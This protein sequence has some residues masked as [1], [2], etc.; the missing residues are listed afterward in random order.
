MIEVGIPM[1][2][3][4]ELAADV[5]LPPETE[6]PA[7]TI[8]V[9]TPY[10]KSLPFEDIEAYRDAGYVGVTYDTRG[11][12]KSEGVF[13]PHSAS[14]GADGHDVVE[15]VAAQ[16]WCDGKVGA[17]GLSY[18]GWVVFATMAERPPHLC[19]AIPTSA[20]GRWQEELPY[21]YGC[22][23]LY[24]AAWFALVRRRIL[25]TSRKTSE[26]ISVLPVEA[27]GEMIEP[28]GP[29]WQEMLEH[30]TLDELW[31][32]RRWDG[33]YE[34]DVPCLHISGWHDREDLLGTFHHYEEML[35]SSPARER[36]WLL[37]GPWS[38]L[39][40]RFPDDVYKGIEA[41][42]G[43]L[44]MNA[45]HLRFFDHF[46]RGEQNGVDQEPRVR[47][48]DPGSRRWEV[49]PDWRGGTCEHELFLAEGHALAPAAGSA[50][51]DRYRYDPLQP[52]GVS[53][54][55]DSGWNPPLDL[56]GLEAQP[57]VLSW[58]GSPLEQPLTVRGWGEVEL[59][60]ATDGEDT[61][62]HLKL[63]DVNPEGRSLWVAWGCLRA[64][65]GEDAS[66]PS[67]VTPGEPRQYSIELT[68]TFHTF[69]AGHRFRL[70]LA[71][72]EF[73]WFAR[74]L[75]TF[76]PIAKQADPRTATNT[77]HHGT[78]H[79]SCLRLQVEG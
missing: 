79:P 54:D 46:L 9:G 69:K 25:D 4:L 72:S 48:Y 20:S 1:R 75:N 42:G 24:C 30:D 58:T 7:P 65:Y 5:H 70:V 32:S 61:E 29:G 73:P 78:V 60:A 53:F 68:P 22:L 49:R 50:G 26:L 71:S 8:V 21:T 31:R 44:N 51:E 41:P 35:A 74:N 33:A 36:Q 3:G 18:M 27:I 12:G 66:A 43:A 13:D 14:D 15:W 23:W 17:A 2:D 76:G 38:H 56:A 37:V 6:L 40:C 28:A 59:W 52:N 11:R 77:V 63:A 67:P 64:S 34:F 45:I 10:D 16:E 39:S 55:V 57:G 47:M 62:W 19:A